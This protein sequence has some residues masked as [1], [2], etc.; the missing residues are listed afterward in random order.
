MKQRLY[1]LYE[2]VVGTNFAYPAFVGFLAKVLIFS[3][4]TQDAAIFIS[5]STLFGYCQYLK[6]KR[7]E[8]VRISQ[9]VQK[10]VDD[11]KSKL[12]ALQMEKTIP[13]AQKFF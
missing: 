13:K 10:Q 12:N 11:M 6:S 2:F 1:S 5:L 7:I 8:P 9:E 3:A 4:T